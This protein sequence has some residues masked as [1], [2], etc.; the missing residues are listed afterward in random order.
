VA[1]TSAE[2]TVFRITLPMI[3]SSSTDSGGEG[4]PQ[5]PPLAR[6]KRVQSE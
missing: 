4:K 5:L 2:G 3:S 1:K 6:A